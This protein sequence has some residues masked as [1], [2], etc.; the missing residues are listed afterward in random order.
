MAVYRFRIIPEDHEDVYRD[1]EI[2]SNQTFEDFHQA[3]QQAVNF[4]NSQMAS[5]YMSN[6][7]WR[8]GREVTLMDM[9]DDD[10]Q[11]P[12]LVMHKSI[13]SDFID[14]PHQKMI[15]VFDFMALWTFYIELIKIIPTPDAKVKYPVC[16]KS[17][18]A[19]PKQYKSNV[20]PPPE[21][22][23]ELIPKKKA[24]GIFEGLDE[25]YLAVADEEE[26][27]DAFGGWGASGEEEEISEEEPGAAET[28]FED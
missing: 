26:E 21:E 22:E 19:A 20:L 24:V 4:D 15:Y 27:D 8:K 5:F 9:S 23:D 16:V 2:K 18:G 14:D 28:Q 1:I 3:I 6:D 11:E 25:E 7:N 13:M 10:D 12:K 17:V